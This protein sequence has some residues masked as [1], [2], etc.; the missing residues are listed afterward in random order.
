MSVSEKISAKLTNYTSVNLEKSDEEIEIIQYGIQVILVNIF[1][2]AIL[3]L[4]AYFLNVFTYTLIAFASF[5]ILRL[6][7]A[8]V[9]ADSSLKCIIINYIT[10][11]GNVY[12]S[13]FLPLTRPI[14]AALFIISLILYFMYS[15]ADTEERP[16]ISKKLR[17]QLKIKTILVVT[18]I[19]IICVVLPNSIY[20]NLVTFSVLEESFYITPFA[21][22]LFRKS[23]RNYLN[24]EL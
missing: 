5:G 15:P 24:V 3:F 16:L 6:F 2:M 8:G 21:Y 14:T 23:Y 22:K 10:F 18:T 17:K 4:T 11:L 9:H 7:A 19:G 13:L 12:L 20:V 1:K